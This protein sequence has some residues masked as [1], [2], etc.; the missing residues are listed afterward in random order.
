MKIQ[1]ILYLLYLF[2]DWKNCLSQLV[3]VNQTDYQFTENQFV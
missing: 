3:Q 2:L 1:T